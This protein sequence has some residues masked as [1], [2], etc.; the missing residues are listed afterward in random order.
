[1]TRIDVL[2]SRLKLDIEMKTIDHLVHRLDLLYFD[3]AKKAKQYADLLLEVLNGLDSHVKQLLLHE[4]KLIFQQEMKTRI[5]ALHKDFDQ[6]CF[7]LR[8]RP[9]MIVLEGKCRNCDRFFVIDSKI[10]YYIQKSNLAPYIP[11]PN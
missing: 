9:D 2:I 11:I 8:D 5:K 3:D 4:I 1:L 7:E 6:R 10:L